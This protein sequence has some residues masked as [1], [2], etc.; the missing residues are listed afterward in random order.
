MDVVLISLDLTGAEPAGLVHR[1]CSHSHDVM[2]NGY[3]Y[4]AAGGL[5]GMEDVDITSD[6]TTI[7]LS[8]SLSGVDPAYRKEIDNGGFKNAPIEVLIGDLPPNS[9]TVTNTRIHFRGTCDTPSTDIDY[10]K[11][12]MTINI[13]A[14]SPFRQLDKTPDLM[15]TSQSS[16]E[17]WHKGDKFFKFVASQSQEEVWRS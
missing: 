2:H 13:D 10:S 1:F 11:G 16:H 3:K 12:E 6:L 17:T 7:G 8:L 15:R 4:T 5:I 14:Q 9:D